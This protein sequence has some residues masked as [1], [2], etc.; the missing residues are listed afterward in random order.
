M[1]NGGSAARARRGGTGARAGVAGE[2]DPCRGAVRSRECHRHRS[3]NGVRPGVAPGWP[4]DHH[5]QPAGRRHDAW[6]QRRR[7]IESGWL[8]HPGPLQC[9]R[10]HTGD[11][12]QRSL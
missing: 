11:P 8:Y 6:H 3:A 12:G 4:A 2:A 10:D 1:R 7:E 9:A 5:R